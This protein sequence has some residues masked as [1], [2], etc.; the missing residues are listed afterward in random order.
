MK[1][2]ETDS[3]KTEFVEP[4]GEEVVNHALRRTR[5]GKLR[6]GLRCLWGYANFVLLVRTAFVTNIGLGRPSF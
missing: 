1:D 2:L 5:G 6:V 4:G 3:L